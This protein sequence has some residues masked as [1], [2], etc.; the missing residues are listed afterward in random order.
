ML[1]QNLLHKVRAPTSADARAS[2]SGMRS[3]SDPLESVRPDVMACRPKT[4]ESCHPRGVVVPTDLSPVDHKMSS[5]G[6]QASGKPV[7]DR[8]DGVSLASSM[9]AYDLVPL[10]M[11]VMLISSPSRLCSA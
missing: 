1:R 10:M 6:A 4:G 7:L 5:A 2:Y 3:W 11:I 9:T 8:H